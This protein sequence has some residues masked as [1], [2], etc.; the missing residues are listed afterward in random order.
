M[1]TVNKMIKT[2]FFIGVILQLTHASDVEGTWVKQCSYDPIPGEKKPNYSTIT[3]TLKQRHIDVEINY[4]T[5]SACRSPWK[6]M[7]T[8]LQ[9]GTYT[10]S[11]KSIEKKMK[12]KKRMLTPVH[13]HISHYDNHA[14]FKTPS[15]FTV[16]FDAY[17][18]AYIHRNGRAYVLNKAIVTPK[19][20]VAEEV[21]KQE[22]HVEVCVL[23][24]KVGHISA[25]WCLENM[26]FPKGKFRAY[27]EAS[28]PEENGK[29]YYTKMCP[30]SLRSSAC[31]YGLYELGHNLRRWY[32][33]AELRGNPNAR[34]ACENQL[35]GKWAK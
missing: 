12:G 7:P 3:A 22:N 20:R 32:S 2:V 8:F 1:G 31:V 5:D 10:V 23:T 6:L 28:K 17:L 30:S 19:A 21:Y 15:R 18:K 24:M 29:L 4:F 14:R 13:I 34:K 11:S 25:S 16:Y 35:R 9:T 33:K 26:T 27:C